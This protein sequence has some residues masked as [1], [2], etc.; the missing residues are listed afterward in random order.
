MRCFSG[1]FREREDIDTVF[2]EFSLGR[3]GY[4]RSIVRVVELLECARDD[5]I[6]DF[7]NV[8]YY[9]NKKRKIER[10]LEFCSF[11]E[12]SISENMIIS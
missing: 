2:S 10:K 8:R 5:G 12:F 7:H 4:L 3:D 1:G 6:D 11:Y 9:S